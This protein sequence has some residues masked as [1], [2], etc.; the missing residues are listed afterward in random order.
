MFVLFKQAMDKTVCVNVLCIAFIA[1]ADHGAVLSM[2]SGKTVS[3]TDSYAS[4]VATCVQYGQMITSQRRPETS[5]D[6]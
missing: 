6:E 4:V 5:R 3:V 2:M 1:Q